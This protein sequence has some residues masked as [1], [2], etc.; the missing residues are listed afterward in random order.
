VR[1]DEELA[2]RGGPLEGLQ[3][4][5]TGALDRWSRN[6]VEELIKGLGGKVGTSVTKN[7]SYL[8]A[9]EGGGSKRT[10]AEQLGTPILDEAG[11]R[12][13]LST[14]GWTEQEQESEQR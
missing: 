7:T 1:Q 6:E 10:K 8:V 5:V 3:I 13:L 2:S 4:V 14:H 12:E 11:L 9:G